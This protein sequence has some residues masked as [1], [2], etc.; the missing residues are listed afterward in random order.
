[1]LTLGR[2]V[3]TIPVTALSLLDV[4]P[5][6]LRWSAL[7]V[8]MGLIG[9]EIRAYLQRRKERLVFPSSSDPRIAG[10]LGEWVRK[11]DRVLIST[12]D[13]SWATGDLRDLLFDKAGKG[14]L[15]L[16]LPKRI[17][18]ATDLEQK[19][20]DVYE[21]S[22]L[23]CELRSRFTIVNFGRTGAEVAVSR[24]YDGQHIIEQFAEGRDVAFGL[25]MDLIDVIM[26]YHKLKGLTKN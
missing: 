9:L 18:L 22:E 20:A 23:D 11:G 6:P 25:A 15:S 3:A 16:V 13:M 2:N 14:D 4:V 24:R 5:V 1:M 19:G 10:F 26:R 8:L 21:F 7:L 12:R 17:P